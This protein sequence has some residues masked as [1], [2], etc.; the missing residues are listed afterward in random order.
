M[1]LLEL[2]KDDPIYIVIVLAAFYGLRRS[3][4]LG[5]KWN[6]IDFENNVITVRHKIYITKDGNNQRVIKGSDKMK[7]K[8]SLR[9]FPLIPFVREALL[10]EKCRQEEYRRVFK[11]SYDKTYLE[12][13]CIRPDG[14]IIDP[15]YVSRHFPW[16]LEHNQL[17][18]IR[19]HDLRHANVKSRQTIFS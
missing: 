14:Q 10:T 17:R 5:V 4:V 15:D 8:A 3:E 19:F 6:A 1:Q 12:Y 11:K 9:S 2:S 13:V 18:V 16:L 7:T